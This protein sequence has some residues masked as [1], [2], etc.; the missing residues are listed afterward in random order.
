MPQGLPRSVHQRPHAG[1]AFG[2]TYKQG[3]A[4][5]VMTDIELDNFGNRG[6]RDDIIIVETVTGMDLEPG[7]SGRSGPV[8]QTLELPLNAR[9]IAGSC[10]GAGGRRTGAP[11]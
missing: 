1:H 2:K 7:G 11:A 8:D 4:H 9:R 3:L 6:D 5:E 10:G